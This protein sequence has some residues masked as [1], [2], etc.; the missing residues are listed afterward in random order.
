MI[1]ETDLS[2]YVL[3]L[4]NCHLNKINN[5]EMLCVEERL[6]N[7]INSKEYVLSKN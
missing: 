3:N 4:K 1:K 5:L 6:I 2:Y 7:H